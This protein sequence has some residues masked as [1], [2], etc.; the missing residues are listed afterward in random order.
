[1]RAL[2]TWSSSWPPDRALPALALV[3]FRDDEL[4]PAARCRSCSESWRARGRRAPALSR[5]CLSRPSGRWPRLR[6]PTL[7]IF[8]KKPV[9]I[10]SSSPRRWP[11]PTSIP[12]DRARRRVARPRRSSTSPA[13]AAG[14]GAVVPR[15]RRVAAR[16]RRRRGFRSPGG[17]PGLG[18]ARPRRRRVAFRHELARLAVEEAIAPD[19][20]VELHRECSR[21][22]RRPRTGRSTRRACP[23][24]PTRPA[25]SRRCCATRRRRASA[26]P[27]CASIGGGRAVRPRARRRGARRRTPG[28]AVGAP[29]VRE[30]PDP[31]ARR[32]HRRPPGG[33]RAPSGSVATACAR[34][35]TAGGCRAGLVR[36]RRATA[37]REAGGRST[38]WRPSRRP[39]ARDGLQQRLAA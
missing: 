6:A 19:R 14:G 20:R 11:P 4:T 35:T 25:T 17:L 7:T 15:G 33:A 31:A 3:S 13:P 39:R 32:G 29:V 12:G 22:C 36:R 23:T 18:D 34:G 2:W 28:P 21:R 30:L 9:A 16:G 24:T 27:G 1:M 10:R 26:P 5:R 37:V 38:C 8:L